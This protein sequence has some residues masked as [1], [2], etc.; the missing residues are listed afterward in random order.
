MLSF[1]HISVTKLIFTARF[2]F[3]FFFAPEFAQWSDEES[4][5]AHS[6][7]YMDD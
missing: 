6:F 4:F 3:F 2:S 5:K 7:R 1:L